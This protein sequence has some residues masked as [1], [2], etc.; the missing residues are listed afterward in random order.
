MK[1][2][3]KWALCIDSVFE[4]A[5]LLAL[6]AMTMIVIVQVFTRKFFHFVFFWSEEITLLLMVW[7]SFMGIAVGFREKLHIA[8]DSLT[9]LFGDRFNRWWDKCISLCVL[10]F[11]AYL[12]INGWIFTVDQYANRLPATGWTN[13]LYYIVMPITGLMICVYSSLSLL[14]METRRHQ[15]LDEEVPR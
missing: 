9:N 4:H 13:S 14:G 12:V 8:M 3:R 6:A 11:G 1:T 2:L 5:A 15:D 7:S 10:C